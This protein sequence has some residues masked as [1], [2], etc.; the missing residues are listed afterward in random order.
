M[1]ALQ[2]LLVSDFGYTA[3]AIT[4]I[5]GG[6]ATGAAIREG[7]FKLA[8]RVGAS[9]S[10]FLLLALRTRFGPDGLEMLPTDADAEQPWTA[11]RPDEVIKLLGGY[12]RNGFMIFPF[13]VAR[14]SSSGQNA[15][16][17]V[18]WPFE[19]L[20]AVG[21]CPR[22][23]RA[24]ADISLTHILVDGLRST[25]SDE[26]SGDQLADLIMRRTDNLSA[27]PLSAKLRCI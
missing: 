19:N 10:A 15:N 22:H 4:T 21:V 12:A 18:Y 20:S 11:I 24:P 6:N 5:T 2:R 8:S 23:V 3:D 7:I 13:C 17:P 26:I 27:Q 14:G 1:D 25:D 16:H 9:D